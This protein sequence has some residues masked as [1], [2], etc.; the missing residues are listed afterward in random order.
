MEKLETWTTITDDADRT[1]RLGESIGAK[2]K[3]GEIVELV[4]DIGSGK[5]TFVKGIAKGAGITELVHSP[6]FTISNEY[7]AEKL[8]IYHYDF[9][10]L[11]DPGLMRLELAEI[12]NDPNS[13]VIIEWADVVK[14]VL[15]ESHLS[16][17]I[18]PV[19]E[20]SREFKFVYPEQMT[21][22]IQL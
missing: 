4:G 21:K 16:I 2:L 15:P 13:V 11:N 19:S 20:D 1:L 12:L 5:T 17:S 9:H 8:T 6:S 7:K 14:D 10:R 3:G 22:L 18:R